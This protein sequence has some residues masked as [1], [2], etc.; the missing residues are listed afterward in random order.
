MAE[1]MTG[2]SMMAGPGMNP[3][4]QATAAVVA[5]FGHL[6][7]TVKALAADA[8]EAPGRLDRARTLLAGED[9]LAVVLLALAGAL[10]A[11]LLLA[12]A[13][14]RLL[15]PRRRAVAALAPTDAA[16]FAL[17]LFRAAAID[18][19]PVAIYGGVAAG[20]S[21]LL[22]GEH[23][24]V[25]SGSSTFRMVAGTIISTSTLSWLAAAILAVPLG[26]GRPGL[27]CVPLGDAEAAVTR[28]FVARIIAFG[29][30]SWIVAASLSL[31]AIGEGLPRLLMIAAGFVICAVVLRALARINS[32][33][34]GFAGFCHT[35]AVISVFGLGA[36][37]T[38]A[39]LSGSTPPFGRLWLTVLILVALPAA[40][41]MTTSLLGRMTRRLHRHEATRRIYVPAA[42]DADEELAAVE[43]PLAAEERE[44]AERETVRAADDLGEVLQQ[45][46]RW[47]L[48]IAASWLLGHAWGLHLYALLPGMTKGFVD[49][50]AEAVAT[51]LVGWYAWRL[52]ETGLALK[53]SGDQSG[54]QSRSRT[55]QPLLRTVGM[56]IIGAVAVMSALSSLGLNIAPLLA[57]AGVVG[58]AVGFGAQ[59]LVRDLFSGAFYL[60]EDVFRIGDYIEGGTAK[61]TVERITFRT[62]ALRHQ[63][64]PLH[65]VPYGALGTVRNNSRDWVIDKFEIP[66]PI[67]VDSEQ[68]RRMVKKIGAEMLEV[69]EFAKL[70]EAPLK[71]KLYRIE[72]GVK[73]FRCKV[74]TPPGKQFEIRS[75]AYRRI[76]AA[77]KE[78]G[79]AFA[80][81]TPRVT[82]YQGA[83]GEPEALE[84]RA[85]A[86]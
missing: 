19:A 8:A 17:G 71:A 26:V 64:G 7:R 11:A 6:G 18:L 56:G 13:A 15:R 35:L 16:G 78:S 28:R 69:P 2:M 45:I 20:A 50:V 57:S 55:V 44:V 9:T 72:P 83:L 82:L 52:F 63:N 31:A 53:L 40:D 1:G 74:Q 84:T 58:I 30:A 75:E 80:D 22:F 27:R 46:V 25:F 70:I 36:A 47:V 73:I 4:S 29:A 48:A 76:E 62:V 60:I 39:L 23:G 10:A 12:L 59:T 5:A 38:V 43:R 67:A 77:L 85:V 65:F 79:I 81:L 66:L 33:F 41:G 86:G 34:K 21:F 24:L 37:W 32:R 61:G 54:T 42:G 3:L 51:L 68:I 49:D 14:R